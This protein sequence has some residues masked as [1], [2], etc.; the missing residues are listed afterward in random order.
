MNKITDSM[1]NI[2]GEADDAGVPIRLEVVQLVRLGEFWSH[3]IL[4]GHHWRLYR[5]ESSGAGVMLA[6][7]RF[8]LRPDRLYVLPPFCNLRTW[9][10]DREVRQLYL[11]FETPG[12]GAGRAFGIRELELTPALDALL[13]ALQAALDG[14]PARRNIAAAALSCAALLALP[15]ELLRRF[16]RDRAIDRVLDYMRGH[17]GQE[18]GVEALARYGNMS[19]NAF[20]K[21]FRAATGSTPYRYLSDLRYACAAR[22]LVEGA[23]SIDEICVEIAI[24]DRFHFSREFK[25]RYGLSPAAYRA[26]QR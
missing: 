12:L 17:F 11:H 16:G 14:D 22:L 19:V 10:E 13:G 6:G 26:S 25:R 24:R 2:T 4:S 18:L 1:K 5:N 20:L 15:P 9:C 3:G 23:L 7:R 21:R 8:P